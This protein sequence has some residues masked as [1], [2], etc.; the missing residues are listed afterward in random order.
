MYNQFMPVIKKYFC[1]LTYIISLLTFTVINAQHENVPLDHNVY[2]FLKEMKVK[3]ILDN[4]HEDNPSMS[5]NEIKKH[6]FII[7]EKQN[8]LSSTE[9]KLMNKFLD[10][11]NDEIADSTNRY[12]LIAGDGKY[13]S[14]FTD[15]FSDKIKHFYSYSDENINFYFE[16]LGRALYGQNFKPIINNSEI[17]DIGVRGRGTLLDMIGYSMTIQKGG[18]S[19]SQDLAVSFDP[20]LK[21]NFKFYEKLENIGNYDFTEGYLRFYTEPAENMSAVL[22]IGREKLKLGYGYG[23]KFVLSGDHPML[24][25][26]KLDFN[27]GVFSFSSLHGSTVGE[28]SVDRDENFTKMFA[29]NKFKLSLENLFE[30]GIGESI[31]YSGRGIDFAYLNPFAFYKY[32]EMSLQDRDNGVVFLDFQSKFLKNLEFQTTFFLDE[33]IL[34]HLQEMDLFSNKTAYQ[35]GIFWYE[36]FSLNDLSLVLEYTKIRPYVYSHV[37]YKNSYTAHGELLGHRIGPNADEIYSSVMYNFNE[38]IR[39]KFEYQFIRSGENM[40]DALGNVVLNSGGDPF[41]A[42]RIDI[43]PQHISFLDGERINQNIFT[44]NLR[45]EPIREIY[46]DI[47]FKYIIENN[48]TEEITNYT[49][50]GFLRMIFEI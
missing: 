27:Y 49:S 44:L 37:N 16:V 26:I 7:S 11:F 36:P 18:V 24:D 3:G 2:Y 17:Y 38:W 23:S 1:G 40:F 43:D 35:L 15:L 42:H 19:G 13:S 6:L 30:F 4:I 29:Y 45:L 34:S 9:T 8:E 28:F 39:G 46:F 5:R 50:Y 48:L 10:E 32:V 14:R 31:I 33:N 47:L 21:Y 12:Q 41:F 25:F 22:Q 20:R